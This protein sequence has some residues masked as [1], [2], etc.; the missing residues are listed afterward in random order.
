MSARGGRH[1]YG[2]FGFVWGHALCLTPTT[3]IYLDGSGEFSMWKPLRLRL[4]ARNNRRIALVEN[5]RSQPGASY[6]VGNSFDGF[7][8]LLPVRMGLVADD[9]NLGDARRFPSLGEAVA[10]STEFGGSVFEVVENGLDISLRE[11][12]VD[13]SQV[14]AVPFDRCYRIGRQLVVGPS[15]VGDTV[16]ATRQRVDLLAAAG[17]QTIVTLLGRAELFWMRKD[18][19]AVDYDLR[20]DHHYFPV[21]DGDAPADEQMTKI[22]DITDDALMQGRKVYLHCYGGRGR[23]GCVAGCLLARHGI[24]AG[25]DA[26]N[27]L[28]EIRYEHG[29]FM[30]SPESEAQRQIVADWREGQ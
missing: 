18:A 9:Q 24:A 4:V 6:V 14:N 25:V 28:A 7:C 3:T 29:L 30:P 16:E 27:L 13:L 23:S 11:L 15:F 26:L 20:F 22:L 12:R 5:P 8:S 17:V 21:R 1:H 2:P 19:G 10:A